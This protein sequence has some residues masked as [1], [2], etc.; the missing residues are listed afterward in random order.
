[1][2]ARSE[3]ITTVQVL[4][5]TENVFAG[6]ACVIKTAGPIEKRVVAPDHAVVMAVSSDPTSRN[7]SRSRPDSIYVRQPTNRMGVVWIVRNAL[8]QATQSG[9]ESE[10]SPAANE[11]LSKIARG[12]QE[13][14]CVSRTDFD[15]R[16]ALQLGNGYG[17]QPTIYGGGEVYRMIDEFATSKSKLVFTALTSGSSGRA[18]RGAEGTD[19]RWNVPGKLQAAGIQFCLAGTHLLDQA[20]FAVRF[21]LAPEQA[22]QAVTSGP[23]KI[24]RIDDRVGSIRVGKDADLVALS[25]DPWQPTSAIKWTMVAGDIYGNNESTQ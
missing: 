25:G 23:A 22:L 20:R 16:S 2:E 21:G 4:P 5:A 13:V 11:L 17:Y 7:R 24:L 6:M 15:I 14:C 1:M 12:T 3:G 9:Q 19:L 8:Q 18:L 10:L